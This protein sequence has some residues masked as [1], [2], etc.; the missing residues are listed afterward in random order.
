MAGAADEAGVT[1]DS[2]FELVAGVDISLVE[3]ES[4]GDGAVVEK[5]D[6]MTVEDGGGALEEDVS[7]VDEE[8]G[9]ADDDDGGGGATVEDADG[10]GLDVGDATADDE[11]SPEPKSTGTPWRGQVSPM[12]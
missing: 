10:T 4:G 3:N 9:T 1:V 12:I 5:D 11:V 8:S 2:T 6:S 7:V